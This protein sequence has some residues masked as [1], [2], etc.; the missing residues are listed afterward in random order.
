MNGRDFWI[1]F[2][3]TYFMIVTLITLAMWLV[4]KAVMPEQ[5]FGY[6]AFAAPLINGLVGTIPN[7]VLY[8]K[9]ELKVKELLVRKALQLVLIEAGV[10]L[11]AWYYS[12]GTR[13]DSRIVGILA[14]A[15]FSVPRSSCN[16]TN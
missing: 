11:V 1:D 12:G 6:D 7:F 2:I 10:L 16:G 15:A 8:S 9:R 4:G 5:T 13:L 3:R 14:K